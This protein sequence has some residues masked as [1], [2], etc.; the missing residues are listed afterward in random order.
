MTNSPSGTSGRQP[1]DNTSLFFYR[2]TTSWSQGV[3]LR[4]MA[5]FAW[6]FAKCDALRTELLEYVSHGARRANDAE[7]LFRKKT[8][9]HRGSYK[10]GD[11]AGVAKV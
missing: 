8:A 9:A 11:M 6:C 3:G 2:V 7:E 10:G 5:R 1:A 4:M